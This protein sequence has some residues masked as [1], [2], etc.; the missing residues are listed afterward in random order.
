VI[1][2]QVVLYTDLYDLLTDRDAFIKKTRAPDIFVFVTVFIG[3]CFVCA[4]D[5]T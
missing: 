5:E 1:S 2:G 4:F 3:T